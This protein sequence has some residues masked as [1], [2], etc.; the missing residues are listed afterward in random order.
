MYDCYAVYESTVAGFN[1]ARCFRM[2]YQRMAT[3]T[4]AVNADLFLFPLPVHSD[5]NGIRCSIG[6]IVGW[7]WSSGMLRTV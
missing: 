2:Q 7:S 1:S 4:G 6:N 5:F 3:H